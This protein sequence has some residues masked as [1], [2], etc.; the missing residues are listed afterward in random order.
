MWKVFLALILGVNMTLAAAEPKLVSGTTMPELKGEYLTGE[1]AVMPA[2]AHG[3]IA[4]FALGFSYESRYPVEDWTNEFRKHY[5][6][7]PA[8][9]FYEVPM[10]GGF[11]RLG[12]WFIDSGMRRATPQ[13][14]HRNVITVYGGTGPWKERLSVGDEKAAYLILLDRNG[15]V[16][17]HHS[18]KF[19]E[20]AFAA[21]KSAVDQLLDG[22]RSSD[23]GF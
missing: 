11:G 18:G 7:N 15:V 20:S 22:A 4:L 16:R 3:K 10:I 17:W 2:A 14:L 12:R 5:G 9:V 6:S 13:N 19:D 8:T 21:L 1:K 23:F